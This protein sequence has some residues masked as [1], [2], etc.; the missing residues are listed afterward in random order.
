[1]TG[2]SRGKVGHFVSSL[3]LPLPLLA[4]G[5]PPRTPKSSTQSL[6]KNVLLSEIKMKSR[7]LKLSIRVSSSEQSEIVALASKTSMSVSNYARKK[8]LGEP[9]KQIIVPEINL[10][11]YRAI[12]D[13]SREIKTVGQNLNQTT[14]WMHSHRA[15]PPSLLTTIVTTQHQIERAT[16]ILRQIQL[17]TVGSIE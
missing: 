17:A 14:K 10:E 13:L 2:A 3:P 15:A 16:Q 1:M 7:D 12:V 5:K 11:S 4:R 9:T 8:L 6:I